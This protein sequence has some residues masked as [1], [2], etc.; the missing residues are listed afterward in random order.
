MKDLC[1]VNKQLHEITVRNLYREVTLDVGSPADTK[2][3]AFLNPRNIGLQYI[4]QLDLYLADINDKCN[5]LQQANFAVRMIIEFLPENTLEK[6][7][8]HPWSTFSADN[9]L[10]LYKK[11][12]R[13]QW[14]E[15][16]AMDR[17]VVPELEKLPDIDSI[18]Q[19]VKKLGLYPDNRE[20]LN[21]S[22]FLLKR[23]SKLDKLTLH[24]S[25]E[26][27]EP[28]I[29]TRELNDSST[30]PGLITRTIFSHMQPF[31]RCTPLALKEL[32]LQKINLRYAAQTYCKIINFSTV[33]LLRVCGCPGAD[34]LFAELS[35]S[36][37]LP[38]KL[39]TLEFKHDDNPEN[40]AMNALDGF[41]CLVSGIKTMTLDISYAKS[42]PAHGGIARHSKTLRELNVHA[43][44]GDSDDEELVFE[45]EAFQQICK[46]CTKLEQL[47]AAF[48]STSLIRAN[49]ESFTAFEVG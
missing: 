12:R 5:Q 30:E 39:E 22:H 33:K 24:A 38:E 17:D 14:M 20:V 29:P 11:Q 49:S 25:F 10:L 19:G 21:L 36:T 1:L 42:L 13:M 6:L 34:A 9:L 40:D 2:L 31:S 18:V 47:S 48:P 43:S 37:A 23:T 46:D 35:K 41:L 16:I 26:D 28:P 3:S 4:R 8:W 7:S 45:L 44:R 32:A 15:A 27:H